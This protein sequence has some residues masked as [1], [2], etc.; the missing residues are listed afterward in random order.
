MRKRVYAFYSGQVQGVGFR[1]ITVNIAKEVD[2]RG[3]VKNLADGR[4]LLVAEGEED[5]LKDFLNRIFNSLSHSIDIK[6]INIEWG[7]ATDEFKDFRV[8]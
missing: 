8:R 7:Q 2:V 1:V 4:V 5:T 6:D 3:W